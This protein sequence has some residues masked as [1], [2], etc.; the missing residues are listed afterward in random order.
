[1]TL[2]LGFVVLFASWIAPGHWNPWVNFQHELLAAVA[3]TLIGLAAITSARQAR[4]P[5][6]RLAMFVLLVA[7]TV[8]RMDIQAFYLVFG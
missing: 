1:M 4:V 8:A 5:W 7:E 3:A 2:L 6:P